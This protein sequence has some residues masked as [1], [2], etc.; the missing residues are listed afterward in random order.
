MR[1][2][3]LRA[4]LEAVAAGK[5]GTAEAAERLAQLPF[6]DVGEAK[7][8]LHREIRSGVAETVY[9][10]GKTIGDLERIVSPLIAAHGRVL[11]TRVSDEQAHALLAR[12]PAAVHHARARLLT[13]GGGEPLAGYRVGVLAAGTADLAVA[14]EAALTSVWLGAAVERHYDVG[15]AGL[16]RLLDNLDDIRRAAALI[17]VAGMDGALPTLVAGLV[18]SPVV[19]V[20]TSVGYG[21]SFGGLAALLTMLNACS[22]GV[23]VVNIDNGYGAAVMAHRICAPRASHPHTSRTGTPA[24][25]PRGTP[26]ARARSPRRRRPA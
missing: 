4:L 14:E 11:V 26:R 16:H 7:L 13:V 5:I 3:E 23:A 1:E 22:P 18:R 20:P 8:D 2:H 19:A 21:A 17:V 9:A 24:R 15:I 10:P 12:H 6:L 25:S